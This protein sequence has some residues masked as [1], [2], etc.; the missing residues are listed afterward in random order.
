MIEE[1]WQREIN[2]CNYVKERRVIRKEEYQ[3]QQKVEEIKR[4]IE[5]AQKEQQQDVEDQKD[6]ELETQYQDLLM[7]YKVEFGLISQEEMENYKKSQKK[8]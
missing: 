5:E 1:F 8:K 6:M 7:K 3:E 2:K 4:A